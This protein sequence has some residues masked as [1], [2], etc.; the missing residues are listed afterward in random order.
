MARQET[1]CDLGRRLVY[2]G[3]LP[4]GI[5]EAFQVQEMACRTLGSEIYAE[6]CG[7]ARRDLD[8]GGVV[9]K[10]FDDWKGSPVPDAVVLRFLGAVHRIVLEGRAAEL[11]SHYPS[12]GGAPRWPALWDA[13]VQVVQQNFTEVRNRLGEQLQTNEV[14]RCAALIGGFLQIAART[15][16]PLRIL[17]IGSSAGLNQAWHR[18]VYRDGD[19]H[20]WGPQDAPV[21]IACRWHGR[22]QHLDATVRITE[23]RGCDI[24]PIDVCD[25][26]QVHKLDSFIWPDQLE[27][28]HQ[29]RAAIAIARHDPPR[30]DPQPAA[31]WLAVR[32][33]EPRTGVASVVFHSTMWW[34]MS[35]GE[36]EAVTRT[37]H[38]A[39]AKASATDPLAWLQME[40]RGRR[41]ADLLLQTWPDGHEV[42]LAHAHPH[43]R[44]VWWRDDAAAP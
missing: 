25:D 28:L 41:E 16:L 6:L 39:G 11:A 14:N 24:V 36:R 20:Y 34:Y 4:E 9:A 1:A 44:E 27:R 12:A 21:Q 8:A 23:R 10:V 43:G 19:T 33:S 2:E 3:M 38:A 42:L 26:R 17:E 13:F 7:R 32:L 29:L 22:P 35:E 31:E 5:A 37:I 18:Y 40:I 15:R 30:I